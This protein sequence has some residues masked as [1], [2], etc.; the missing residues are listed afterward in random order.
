MR[1][2]MSSGHWGC[3]HGSSLRSAEIEAILIVDLSR[4]TFD[5]LYV[6]CLVLE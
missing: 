6:K 3:F 4:K 1:C 5:T 2:Q